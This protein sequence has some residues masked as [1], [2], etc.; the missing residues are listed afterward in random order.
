MNPVLRRASSD[1]ASSE[2]NGGHC[3]VGRLRSFDLTF[4]SQRSTHTILEYVRAALWGL[5]AWLD[6]GGLIRVPKAVGQPHH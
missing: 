1:L 5:P 6:F 3:R 4:E 2:L